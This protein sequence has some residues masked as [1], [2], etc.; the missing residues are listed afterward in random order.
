MA[1]GNYSH[2]KLLSLIKKQSQ[3]TQGDAG[4]ITGVTAGNGLSGG[5]SSG[6]VSLEIDITGSADGTNITVSGSDFVLIADASDNNAVKRVYVSQLTASN[7]EP[8]GENTEIQF[9]S[10][11]AFGASSNFTF[12]GSKL[13]ITGSTVANGYISS[14]HIIPLSDGTYVE[15]SMMVLFLLQQSI[16]KGHS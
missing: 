13:S 2:A 6:D 14:S 1:I 16:M 3:F 5:G 7:E 9:N 11:G 4:D 10:N 12:D 15:T 8:A